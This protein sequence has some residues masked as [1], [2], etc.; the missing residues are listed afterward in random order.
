[1]SV[2]EYDE[3]C[4]AESSGNMRCSSG[5]STPT[6]TSNARNTRVPP[7][8]SSERTGVAGVTSRLRCATL[9]R[10]QPARATLN[11]DDEG[12][13]HENF[14]EHCTGVRLEYL[15]HDAE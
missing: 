7:S 9:L 12:D 15:V 1:M 13:E 14:R 11:E 5:T 10:E 4:S 8:P 6:A 3:T 2:I